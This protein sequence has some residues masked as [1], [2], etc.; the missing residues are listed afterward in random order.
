MGV[1]VHGTRRRHE[2]WR[3]PELFALHLY[4]YDGEVDID[5]ERFRL[6]PGVVSIVPPGALMEYT[7]AG[8]SEHLYA[9]FA[10]TGSGAERDIPRVQDAGLEAG[11][12][13]DR[14][15]AASRATDPA[16]RRADLWSMLWAIATI[17]QPADARMPP[18]HPVVV[19][20]L[21]FVEQNLGRQL[22]V[23]EIAA[24]M[25]FSPSHLDRLVRAATGESLSA[26]VR[27]RRM[28]TAAHLLRDTSQSISLVASSVGIPDLHAFNKAC[29]AALGVSP[30]RIREGH[31]GTAST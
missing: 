12:F 2:R 29:R 28:E 22:T 16:K 6:R 5:G 31:R 3:L 1:G 23:G 15:H 13:A 25:R 11:V 17:R 10:A 7:F 24:A 21:A 8:P 19:E 26:V 14:L 9:H 20:A 30:R 4:R 18:P 27:R